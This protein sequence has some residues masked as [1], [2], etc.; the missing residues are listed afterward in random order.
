MSCKN[1][2]W[3]GIC[4]IEKLQR[5]AEW[6]IV[7]KVNPFFADRLLNFDEPGYIIDWF[8]F[9]VS[10]VGFFSC[11]KKI[12]GCIRVEERKKEIKGNALTSSLTACDAEPR[13]GGRTSEDNGQRS[14]IRD[15]NTK[16][17]IEPKAHGFARFEKTFG[18]LK[19]RGSAA[20]ILHSQAFIHPSVF[21]PPRCW[22]CCRLLYTSSPFCLPIPW[23]FSL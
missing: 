8:A 3:L 2:G 17:S 18:G 10:V 5:R 20:S 9:V 13:R 4:E 1:K 6:K 19:E 15:S 16:L 21:H 12:K 7:S 14:K 22:W 23:L 11:S